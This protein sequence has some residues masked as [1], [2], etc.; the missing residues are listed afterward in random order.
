MCPSGLFYWSR[1]KLGEY[2]RSVS[3]E[4]QNNSKNSAWV[5]AYDI[6][7][8]HTLKTLINLLKTKRVENNI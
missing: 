8:K 6:S 5:I 2:W 1:M 7:N 4:I 3:N